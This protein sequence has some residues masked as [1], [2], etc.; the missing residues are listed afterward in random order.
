[1]SPLGPPVSRVLLV[2]DFHLHYNAMLAGG[3]E[4]AGV[5]VTLLTR[6]HDLEFGGAEGAAA[7]FIR[8]AA[9]GAR[10]V[11]LRG[12]VRSPSGW[13]QAL[14]LR[15]EL[16]GAEVVHLQEAAAGNDVRLGLAAGSRR[17]RYAFTLHDPVL[18]PGEESTPLSD[19][20]D[21]RVL[22]RA[23]LI[24]VHGDALR[25]ELIA[26]RA[27]RAPIVVVPH[28]VDPAEVT[29][30]PAHPSILFFGRIHHYKGLDTLLDSMDEVWESV[31]E[32]SLTIAGEGE[33]EPHVAL[34]DD[35]VTVRSGHIPEAEVP[36]LIRA[37]T[38]VV[39]PY[40]QAS[41][42]GV[43]SRVKPYGRPQIVTEV[44]GL[45]E[46]VADGSGLVV[47]PEDPSALARAVVS[48]L[49][50]RALAQRLAA[51]GVATATREGSWDAVA[52]RTLA[53]Y[54]EHLPLG[55]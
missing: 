52:E 47:P 42:S 6:D 8:E 20:I 45:P 28:G 1:M 16:A 19:W 25:D 43:G 18:H 11:A 44:G 54:R 15:R 41:Q 3:L 9:P 39:L 35:R 12:R 26:Q 13:A 22:L 21:R 36:D 48:V 2:C 46:L 40:R 29:P 51:A 30:P 32:A 31:P 37:A 10:H 23:G 5:E 49:S 38:C 24:F 55:S 4:R 50:D 33:I 34:E 7:G 27:P 53:A 17:G 14:R